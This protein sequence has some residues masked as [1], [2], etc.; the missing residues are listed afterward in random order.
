MAS[1]CL[2][3]SLP[4]PMPCVWKTLKTVHH[5]ALC[6]QSCPTLCDPVVCRP[7]SSSVHRI[8]QAKILARVA[9]S[10]PGDLLDPGIKLMSPVSP[11]LQ[12]DSLVLEPVHSMGNW[13]DRC[14]GWIWQ[15]PGVLWTILLSLHAVYHP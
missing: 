12:A 11:A 4:G 2:F 5:V 14:R 15:R 13:Q 3:C 1:T 9:I 7:P 6:A 8:F 10:P